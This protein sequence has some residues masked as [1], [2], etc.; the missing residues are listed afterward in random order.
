MRTGGHFDIAFLG[1]QMQFMREAQ[2][3]EEAAETL[4]LGVPAEN[5]AGH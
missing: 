2:R 1:N 4:L 3:C 5:D